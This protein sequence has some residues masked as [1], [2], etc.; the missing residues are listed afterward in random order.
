MDFDN[1]DDVLGF[2]GD[3]NS[4]SGSD[5]GGRS[6]EVLIYLALRTR[7]DKIILGQALREGCS[8]KI[9]QAS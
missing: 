5:D 1:Y 8:L 9:W 4:D 2:A 7:T 6:E 3:A